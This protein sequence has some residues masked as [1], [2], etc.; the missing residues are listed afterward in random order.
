MNATEIVS[1]EWDAILIP[2]E[3]ILWQGHPETDEPYM[4]FSLLA[5]V[6]VIGLIVYFL[7]LVL[8]KFDKIVTAGGRVVML[9]GWLVASIFVGYF[10]FG[11]RILDAYKIRHSFYTLTNRRAIIGWT[12][13]GWRRLDEWPI[14]P[15]TKIECD[16]GVPGHVYFAEKIHR[17]ENSDWIE[18]IGFRNIL[19]PE[20][21]FELM[22]RIQKGQA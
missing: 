20:E 7:Y 4:E 5:A 19:N 22:Q 13:M 2:G 15:A 21:V 18:K 17:G 8:S 12:L 10:T 3:R 1:P 6:G 11:K 16:P 9:A 14:R